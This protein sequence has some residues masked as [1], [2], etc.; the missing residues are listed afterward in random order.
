MSKNIF[1]SVLFLSCS[2]ILSAQIINWKSK[3]EEQ[4]LEEARGNRPTDFIV[5]MGEQADLSDAHQLKTKLEKGDFVFKKLS[6]TAT[7]SQK[8]VIAILQNAKAKHYPFVIVNAVAARGDIKLI[9]TLAS[10]PEVGKILADPAVKMQEP[11]PSSNTER[12]TEWGIQKIKADSVWLLGYTGTGVVVGGQDTGYQWDLPALKSKYRG[13]NGSYPVHNY[14]WFDA[15]DSL[16]QPNV[17]PQP[18]NTPNPYG[19][20]VLYPIDDS[21]HGTH[22][23]GTM[24]G[25]EGTNEIGVAPNAKWI[26]CRNMDRG[27]GKPSSYTKCFNWFLAPKDS[28][29]NNPMPSLA[30]DVINNSWGCPPEERCTTAGTYAL[31]EQAVNNL[32]TAGVMVVVSAGNDGNGGNNDCRT[33]SNP[34]SIFENSFSVGATDINDNIAGFSSRGPAITNGIN[35]LKP[36]V[37]APGV[38]VRSCVPNGSYQ[39]WNGTSMAG[40]H[41]AGAVALIIS[42][43]PALRGQVEQIETLLENTAKHL[44]S[45]DTCGQTQGLSPNNTFGYGR[46]DVLAAIAQTLPITLTNFYLKIEDEGNHLFWETQTEA[47]SSHFEV[48]KS[49]DGIN[50]KKIGQVKAAG[51]SIT[52][53]RY[54]YLDKDTFEGV[55]YYRLKEVDRDMTFDYSKILLCRR[56]NKNHVFIGPNPSSGAVIIRMNL[57]AEQNVNVE[58]INVA[59]QKIQNLNFNMLK[60]YNQMTLD[61]AFLPKGYYILQAVNNFNEVLFQKSLLLQ[62]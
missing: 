56:V 52:E 2:T 16:I 11:K 42:A 45:T 34:A 54:D 20:S 4:V 46:I 13:W 21:E 24:I 6:E 3:V 1:L 30:P 41:V 49:T 57:A 43:K 61:L 47:N 7:S 14:N 44:F 18:N 60:G 50:F 62:P 59:G 53:R 51:F 37:S 23:M 28:T 19:Y 58:V 38:N 17:T 26:G 35:R 40:P 5:W 8:N 25:S 36:N 48:E 22:T 9:E 27:W 29:G 31:M 33:I 15:V 39:N 32:K 12:S 10:L 55:C